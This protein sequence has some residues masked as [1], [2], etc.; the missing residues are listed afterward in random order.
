MR[1]RVVMVRSLGLLLLA[2]APKSARASSSSES[3]GGIVVD[4]KCQIFDNTM[5][6][7]NERARLARVEVRTCS[8]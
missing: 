4:V 8:G 7:D 5:I 1:A 2:A 6:C 3:D